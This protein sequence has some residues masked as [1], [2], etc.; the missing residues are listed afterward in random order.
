M[1]SDHRGPAPWFHNCLPDNPE[2][3]CNCSHPPDQAHTYLHFGRGWDR[4]VKA[5]R[6]LFRKTL[7]RNPLHSHRTTPR[8]R[9]VHRHRH[10]DMGSGH[11]NQTQELLHNSPPCIHCHMSIGNRHLVPLSMLRHSNTGRVH[12]A[13]LP[14]CHK[15]AQC[16]RAGN[17]RS[18]SG[19]PQRRFRR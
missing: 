6:S 15:R 4:K 14:R 19:H 2:R 18:P 8:H 7:P 12:K 11:I 3:R 16:S 10:S 17:H 13:A 5:Q 9:S 1:D